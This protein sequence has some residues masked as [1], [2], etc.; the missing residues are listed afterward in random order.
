[1]NCT[2]YTA[3]CAQAELSFQTFVGSWETSFI[4]VGDIFYIIKK[5]FAI[6]HLRIP[7]RNIPKFRQSYDEQKTNF[8]GPVSNVPTSITVR[9]VTFVSFQRT[10]LTCLHDDSTTDITQKALSM[11]ATACIDTYSRRSLIDI[12]RKKSIISC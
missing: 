4:R 8:V 2:R 6:F 12:G 10:E 5:K 9:N 7:D 1:M 3:N 11:D